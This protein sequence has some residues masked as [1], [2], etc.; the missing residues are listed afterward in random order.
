MRGILNYWLNNFWLIT[1]SFTISVTLLVI[2][3]ITDVRDCFMLFAFECNGRLEKFVS[4]IVWPG[5]YVGIILSFINPI[6]GSEIISL[7][8]TVLVNA[9]VVFLVLL[10]VKRVIKK[11]SYHA[12]SNK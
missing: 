4:S 3:L 7:T 5:A 1:S 10:L 2:T 9:I 11:L 12:A 8:V 6:L